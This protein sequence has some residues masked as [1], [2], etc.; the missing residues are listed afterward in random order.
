MW[1]CSYHFEASQGVIPKGPGQKNFILL[2]QVPYLNAIV[3]NNRL[4]LYKSQFGDS[5]EHLG[6]IIRITSNLQKSQ[7]RITFQSNLYTCVSK[8]SHS[9]HILSI[10]IDTNNVELAKSSTTSNCPF[11]QVI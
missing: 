4:L 1:S 11:V 6:H 7:T 5:K 8:W 9:I 3:Q 10:Q 2:A